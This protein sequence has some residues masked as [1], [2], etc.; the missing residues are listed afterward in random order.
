MRAS[1]ELSPPGRQ[2]LTERPSVCLSVRLSPPQWAAAANGEPAQARIVISRRRRAIELTVLSRVTGKERVYCCWASGGNLNFSKV[3]S[4][5]T[6]Y[7]A[8]AKTETET[9]AEHQSAR[10]L[11]LSPI[12]H[13]HPKLA[14]KPAS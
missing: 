3:N 12:A 11:S 8:D 14:S 5:T 9:E 2:T 13:S 10:A 1:S 7:Y 4:S 6:R